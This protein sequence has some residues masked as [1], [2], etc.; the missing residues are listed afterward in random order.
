MKQINVPFCWGTFTG[1]LWSMQIRSKAQLMT[2][3]Q[4]I[5]CKKYVIIYMSWYTYEAE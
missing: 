4:A 1:N 5:C 2:T 3:I